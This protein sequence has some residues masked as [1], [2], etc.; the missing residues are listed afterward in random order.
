MQGYYAV[1]LKSAKILCSE[2]NVENNSDNIL[3]HLSLHNSSSQ[4][5][6]LIAW[7]NPVQGSNFSYKE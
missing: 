4:S 6:E 7:F 1:L 3:M 2:P 5:N